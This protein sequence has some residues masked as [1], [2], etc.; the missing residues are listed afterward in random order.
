MILRFGVS[1]I[2]LPRIVS[3][4]VTTQVVAIKIFNAEKQSY[5]ANFLE[6]D[7]FSRRHNTLHFRLNLGFCTDNMLAIY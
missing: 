7:W 1:L 5:R 3:E 4:K 2:Y 6:L